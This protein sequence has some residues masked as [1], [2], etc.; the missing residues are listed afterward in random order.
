MQVQ[1]VNQIHSNQMYWIHPYPQDLKKSKF[2]NH[3]IE[4]QL[5]P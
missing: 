2:S 5:V 1:P 4:I 3:L